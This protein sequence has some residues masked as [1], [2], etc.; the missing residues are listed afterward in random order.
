[1]GPPQLRDDPDAWMSERVL[2]RK[3]YT[4][5][6]M[7]EFQEQLRRLRWGTADPNRGSLEEAIEAL[8]EH[9]QNIASAGN[10]T[11]LGSA[12]LS[13]PSEHIDVV[14][15]GPVGNPGE[16]PT[17]DMSL[18]VSIEREQTPYAVDEAPEG[19]PR[20][21]DRQDGASAQTAT[22]IGNMVSEEV[23][24]LRSELQSLMGQVCEFKKTLGVDK[25]H[26]VAFGEGPQEA[27][28]APD[29]IEEGDHSV[30]DPAEERPRKR[31]KKGKHG[32]G[33]KTL[34]QE[35]VRVPPEASNFEST[36]ASNAAMRQEVRR[37]LGMVEGVYLGHPGSIIVLHPICM[38]TRCQI[39]TQPPKPNQRGSTL[40][41][42]WRL[43]KEPEYSPSE[44]VQRRRGLS[45]PE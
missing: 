6:D 13:P 41:L 1:M 34:A 21:V 4:K 8:V 16:S 32:K 35:E 25:G 3:R 5:K 28:P 43:L 9:H 40:Q 19:M 23:A 33:K 29:T 10:A 44:S 11:G 12:A 2:K 24:A 37:A 42:P 15:P 22:V 30:D 45:I 17:E 38:L 39:K 27:G 7:R 36:E 31:T 26:L 18:C 20:V 14:A